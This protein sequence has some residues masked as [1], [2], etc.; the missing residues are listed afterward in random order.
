MDFLV[1]HYKNSQAK[2]AGDPHLSSCIAVSWYVFDKY[3]A[4]TDRVTAYGVA[5]LL[6]PHRRKAYLKR[7]WSNNW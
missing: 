7:N 6:A 5:L 2:H 4:G 1:K 3:Y